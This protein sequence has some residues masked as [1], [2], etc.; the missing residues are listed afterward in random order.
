MNVIIGGG[1]S[2]L[3][4]AHQLAARGR[5]FVLLEETGRVG[6][7]MRSG[8]V[9]GHL[10]EWG[11]QRGRLTAEFTAL[12]DE[13]GLRGQLITAPAG[14]PLYVFR[15]GK[16]RRVP[17]SIPEFF[18]SD[19]LTW[20]GKLRIALEPLSGAARDDETVA[21][22]FTRKIGRDAYESLVG[23]LYGGLYASDPREMIVGLSLRHVLREFSVGR[24]LMMPLLRRG[25][26]IVPPDACSFREGMETL[27]RALYERHRANVRLGSPVR[28]LERS[29]AGWRVHTDDDAIEASHVV[30]TSSA[31]STSK[32]LATA[33]PD[34]AQRIGSLK[35]N[36]LVV[37]HLHAATDLRGLG[38][39]VSLAEKLVTRGVTWNDSLFGRTGVYTVYLG[40]AKN[41]WVAEESEETLSRIA[42]DEFRT[43]TGY[44]AS[45][46]AVE[47]ERMPA[48]DRSWAAL[49]GMELPQGLH[50]H[51][52]WESR[53]GIPG[54]LVMA[55]R[56][57][58]RLS[59]DFNDS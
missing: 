27:P 19:L 44:D 18:R 55:R 58:E 38:Y 24:S 12:V 26:S 29:G 8:R 40:G 23:P 45:M 14:L 41:P 20:P 15:R 28:S 17:F 16:L 30:L 49:Q 35:Y 42:V 46:L 51:A 31:P 47:Q 34:A 39:Q 54:R 33:A 22:F 11:P 57:A 6:G 10:L 37:V 43:A 3:A 1:I 59:A 32:L 50:I 25:G 13:L 7:V 36:P 52:N 53:P 5:P 2:G 56:L 9:N 4:L 48:W 21:D